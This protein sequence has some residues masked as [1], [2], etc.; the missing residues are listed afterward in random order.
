MFMPYLF[1][2]V[3]G[4]EDNNDYYSCNNKDKNEDNGYNNNGY[5][6]YDSDVELIT[7][8]ET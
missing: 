4:N 6:E 5:D 8:I 2:H 1:T 7:E 3:H